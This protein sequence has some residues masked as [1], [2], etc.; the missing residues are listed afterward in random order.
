VCSGAIGAIPTPARSCSAHSEGWKN[1]GGR[2]RG[3]TDART[4]RPAG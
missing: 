2:T 4:R 1:T 3:P